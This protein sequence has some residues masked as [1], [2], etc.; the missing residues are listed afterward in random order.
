MKVK[1]ALLDQQKASCET[2]LGNKDEEGV[3]KNMEVSP[4]A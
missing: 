2:L 4:G 3:E 1:E